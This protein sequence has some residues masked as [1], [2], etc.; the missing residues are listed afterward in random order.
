MSR[1]EPDSRVSLPPGT[2]VWNRKTGNRAR[3]GTVMPYQPQYWQGCFPVRFDDEV[4][5]WCD[6]GNVTT[7]PT[8]GH[9]DIPD[10]PSARN[11]TAD[12]RA[13]RRRPAPPGDGR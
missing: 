8:E 6:T 9:S 7:A 5:E 13:P 11:P 2:R 3:Y 10:G 12:R 4:W 1:D